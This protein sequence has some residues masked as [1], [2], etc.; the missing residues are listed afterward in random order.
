[1]TKSLLL[2]TVFTALMTVSG[3]ASVAASPAPPATAGDA[4]LSRPIDPSMA[5]LE[6]SAGK[7]Q[8][9]IDGDANLSDAIAK[10][11]RSNNPDLARKVLEQ[12]GFTA[13]QAGKTKLTLVDHTRSG[14]VGGAAQKIKVTIT[15][16]CCPPDIT[17]IISF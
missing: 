6:Q 16:K 15:V 10:A 13:E 3:S 9:R 11:V 4:R 7:A 14:G 8:V 17:I 2:A 1:M 5:R 12:A